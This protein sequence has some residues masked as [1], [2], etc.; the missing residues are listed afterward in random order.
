MGDYANILQVLVNLAINSTGSYDSG[1]KVPAYDAQ[2]IVA[3]PQKQGIILV[4]K[5]LCPKDVL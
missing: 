3:H 2:A 4:K 5:K 1:K